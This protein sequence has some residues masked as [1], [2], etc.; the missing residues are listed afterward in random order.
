[1]IDIGVARPS[2]HGHAMISTAMAL[3]RAYD[4]RGSGP[5][6]AH[7]IKVTTLTKMTA[8][9]NHEETVSASR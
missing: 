1:M 6:I 7:T 8:G 5:T 3:T 4:S 9:T 2:A